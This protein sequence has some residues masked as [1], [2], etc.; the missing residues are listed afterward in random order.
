[1]KIIATCRLCYMILFQLPLFN[2][3]RVLGRSW[4]RKCTTLRQGNELLATAKQGRP[5]DAIH[6]WRIQEMIDITVQSN[7]QLMNKEMQK[8][9]PRK[10]VILSLARQTYSS[11][12]QSILSRSND[13]SVV[14]LL[15]EYCILK[16]TYVVNAVCIIHCDLVNGLCYFFHSWNRRCIW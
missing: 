1:M 9:K 8:D 15:Q 3:Y 10:D 11:R 14:L 6:Q 2:T 13:L 4:L 7:L 12:R 5:K 16:K